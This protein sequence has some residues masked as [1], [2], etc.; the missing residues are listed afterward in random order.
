MAYV[1]PKES[2]LNKEKSSLPQ[3]RRNTAYINDSKEYQ[4]AV[5]KK[6]EFSSSLQRMSIITKNSKDGSYRVFC[7]GSPEKIKELARPESIPS[8]FADILN[9]YTEVL[10]FIK[11]LARVQSFSSRKS[12]S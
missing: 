4:L 11:S 5:V 2:N 7:K 10:I 1:R 9:I 6:F 3:G 12:N 8:T